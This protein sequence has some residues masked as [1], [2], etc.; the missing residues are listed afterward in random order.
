MYAFIDS[1]VA[2]SRD[3]PIY[4]ISFAMSKTVIDRIFFP[5]QCLKKVA[6][7]QE[8]QVAEYKK[9]HSKGVKMYKITM[10]MSVLKRNMQNESRKGGKMEP[11][12]T[13]PY[14]YVL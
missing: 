14:R 10:G 9:R 3:F 7:A 8:K 11:K 13:G 2:Q 5:L 12:W 1:N 6:A 4:S